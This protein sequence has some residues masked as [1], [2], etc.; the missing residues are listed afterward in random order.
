MEKKRIKKENKQIVEIHIYVHQNNPNSAGG[1]GGT[2][3]YQCTCAQRAINPNG[4]SSPCPV[5]PLNQPYY[6]TCGQ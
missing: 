4:T 3:Y 1:G 2:F 6:V 5:H